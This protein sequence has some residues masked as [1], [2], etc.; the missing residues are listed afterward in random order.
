MIFIYDNNVLDPVFISRLQFAFT[1]TFHILY[2]AFSIGLV[3]FIA[4]MEACWLKTHEIVYYNICRFFTKLFALTFG[5][6]VVSGIVM[7]FQI[8]TNWS[9]MSLVAGDILGT[10]FTYEVMTAF[11]VEAGFLGVLLFGW[12]RV[13]PKLHFTATCLVSFGVILSALWILTA[14]TWMQHPMGY[15]VIDGKLVASSWYQILFNPMLLPRFFHMILSSFLATAC[16]IAAIGAYYLLTNQHPKISKKIFKFA[17]MTM[18]ILSP[19]QLLVGDWVGLVVHEYQ[20]IKSAAIEGVWETS[21]SVPYLIFAV[22]DQAQQKNH[23]EI[24]VPYAASIINTHSLDG[25][26]T[27]LKSVKP[28]KQPPVSTVFFSF[29]AMLYSGMLMILV[30]LISAYYYYY[31]TLFKQRW[32]QRIW[33]FMAPIGFFA[34]ETG[35]ITAESGRQPWVIYNVFSTKAAASSIDVYQVTASF[36]MLFIVYVIIFGF[37][38]FKY[39]IETIKLGPKK[40]KDD[41]IV[42]PFGYMKTNERKHIQ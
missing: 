41:E 4:I 2:P 38:Y 13:S 19:T 42:L 34:M 31:G 14:N 39:L 36:I 11:F 21:G 3:T 33:L 22:P 40:F 5:M 37:F 17:V 20:P 6:G 26:L 18:I 9:G 15:S 16:V 28:D 23:F 24:K 27:G 30:S 1:I 10:L 25:V 29:R 7:E 35:W 8:G 32:L 12:N